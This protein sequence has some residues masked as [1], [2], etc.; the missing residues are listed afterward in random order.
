MQMKLKSIFG[1][2][3]LILVSSISVA[4]QEARHCIVQLLPNEAGSLELGC[5]ST[6]SEALSFVTQSNVQLPEQASPQAISAVVNN[7]NQRPANTNNSRN[8]SIASTYVLAIIYDWTN[9]QN[10]SHTLLSTIS[11]GCQSSNY[12]INLID[13]WDNRAESGI[14]YIDCNYLVMYDT[15]TLSGS[16]NPCLSP[17]SSF[18]LLNNNGESMRLR[19]TYP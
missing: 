1:L 19:K 6:L 10:S 13:A 7:Y 17:C 5:F 14:G 18:G 9:Y 8:V 4:A 11:T 12:S 16:L 2:L 3:L 15:D